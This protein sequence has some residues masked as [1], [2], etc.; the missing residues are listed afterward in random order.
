MVELPL[1]HALTEPALSLQPPPTNVSVGPLEN[2]QEE[3]MLGVTTSQLSTYTY[4]IAPSAF[5]IA[6]PPPMVVAS[7]Q[8]SSTALPMS[9]ILSIIQGGLADALHPLQTQLSSVMSCIDAMES[10]HASQANAPYSPSAPAALWAP[11]PTHLQPL[12]TQEQN[13][14]P[15]YNLGCPQE[16][17]DYT[18]DQYD[19]YNTYN[20]QTVHLHHGT[21]P[22]AKDVK[23]FY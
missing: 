21:L 3:L 1:T 12:G 17:V 11:N 15:Y 6:G 19:D 23:Y 5:E 20:E 13:S 2:S 14:L 9:D 7:S 4:P 8:G 16:D 18:M 10:C 22:V